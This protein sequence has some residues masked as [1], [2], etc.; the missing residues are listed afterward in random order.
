MINLQ[1][2]AVSKNGCLMYDLI[3]NPHQNA[4]IMSLRNDGMQI[5][6]SATILLIPWK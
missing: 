1:N 3:C 6:I 4:I 2:K 5:N